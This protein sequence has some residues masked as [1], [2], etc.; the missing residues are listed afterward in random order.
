MR[1]PFFLV[2]A[3]AALIV[4]YSDRDRM[5]AYGLIM[6]HFAFDPQAAADTWRRWDGTST[7]LKILGNRLHLPSFV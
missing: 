6:D 4:Q 1:S 2:N 3:P 7:E 5:A